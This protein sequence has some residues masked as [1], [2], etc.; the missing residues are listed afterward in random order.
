MRALIPM[1][2]QGSRFT[3]KGYTFPKPLIDVNGKPMIQVVLETLPECSEYIFLCRT[4]HIEKYRLAEL[5]QQLT[6][7]K[8]K[9]V[10]VA[11]LTEGAACTAL[12]AK[13]LI[14]DDEPLLIANSDQYVKYDK[15]N[16]DILREQAD[17][18]GIIFTFDASH[19][20]WSF[21]KTCRNWAVP[22]WEI[23]E[24]AE[25]KPISS[26]ATC[27]L[28]YFKKGSRFVHFAEQMIISDGEGWP[29]RV[30]GEFYIAPVFEQMM[31][32]Q[33]PECH[34]I[35]YAQRNNLPVPP[36]RW[37]Y[38]VLPFFVDRMCGLGT[39]EDLELFLREK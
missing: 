28:Y 23:D 8:A 5:L 11:Q 35:I 10:P 27:G 12:L 7:G 6:N 25:K 17:P 1:A 3:E 13:E 20:K 26:I 31:R 38:K 30:N 29:K 4:E 39:P 32:T 24:V 15:R 22:S 18:D 34:S 9:I 2:G 19:P 33:T 21:V 36:G 37:R 14:N 16:F